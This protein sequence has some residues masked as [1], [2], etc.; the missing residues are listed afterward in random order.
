MKYT[1]ILFF[2]CTSSVLAQKSKNYSDVTNE[3]AQKTVNASF[4]KTPA[5][6]AVVA[7]KATKLSTQSSTQFG[8][9]LTES[10]IGL[11]GNHP[12]KIKLFERTRLDAILKEQE[13]ELSD[14]IKPATAL[15]IGQLAPIDVLLSGT[16][17]KLK[18]YIDVSARLIDVTTGEVV[19]SYSGRVKMNKN[20]ATLFQQQDV[21]TI[22]TINSSTTPLNV[23]IN[24]SIENSNTQLSEIDRCKEKVKLFHPKL[25]DLSSTEKVDAVVRQAMA[26]PFDNNC[27]KLHYDVLY[28]FTR[29]KIESRAYHQFLLQTLDTIKYPTEDDRAS[30]IIRFLGNDNAIDEE[31]WRIGLKTISRVGNYWLSNYLNYLITK[32]TTTDQSVKEKRID[33]YFTL[34]TANKIGLPKPIS[35]EMA[36]FEM[37]EALKSS[38]SLRQLAYQKYS[39]KLLLDD[40]LKSKLFSDL[41]AMYSDEKDLTKKTEI[42][43]WMSD[44]INRSEYE[45]LSDELYDFAKKF[46][47]TYSEERNKEIREKYPETDLTMLIEKCRGKFSTL[48]MSTPYPSQQEDRIIFCVKYNI[49]IVGIIPSMEEADV[50]LKGSN[51]AKQLRVMK[52]LVLMNDKPKKIE[53]TIVALFT[54]R[55]IDEKEKLNDIQTLAM[56]VLGNCKTTNSKA[57]DFML[58]VLPNYGNDTEAAKEALVKIGKPAVA[59]LIAKLDKTTTQDGGLQYQLVVLLGKIGKDAAP[60]AR[61]I[62]RVLAA[63][64][65]SDIQYAAEAALQ[66]IQ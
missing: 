1:Y 18:S 23:T 56:E 48:A 36:Y 31:E 46:N 17:T 24:N 35:Y 30:E 6:L 63:T 4:V 54:H 62:K 11:V 10:I 14:L 20:L 50:I 3:I 65:N 51:I 26:T 21:A 33:Y 38:N 66:M 15:R 12:D 61:S 28:S 9:Y 57:I 45:K 32:P 8:E 43:V 52:L 29:Y 55:S 59:P 42:I 16:Y 64:G 40:K 22:T 5:Q 60:A 44:F 37:T 58:S 13:F 25:N 34:V 41:H 19:M 49:P 27:G 53:S 7:F 47:L 2:L 39:P